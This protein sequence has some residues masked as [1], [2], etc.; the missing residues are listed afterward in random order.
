VASI[1]LD[2]GE[3]L[4]ERRPPDDGLAEARVV[5]SGAQPR[6]QMQVRPRSRLIS[7]KS[8]WTGLPSTAPKSIG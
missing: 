6:Q 8:V 1:R 5:E 7:E 2:L 4:V 3:Q